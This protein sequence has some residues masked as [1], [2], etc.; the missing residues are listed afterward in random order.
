MIIKKRLIGIAVCTFFLFSLLIAQYFK[1]QIIDGE[2]WT[3]EALAQH[4]FI[5]KEPGKRG[6]FFANTSLKKGH[7]EKPLAFVADVTHFHLFID[8]VSIPEEVREDVSRSLSA[9]AQIA[10]EDIRP[11]FDRKSR[12][13]KL[14][15]WISRETKEAIQ[16]WWLPFAKSHKIARNA[17]YFVT[18]YKRSYPFGKLLGQV[19]HTIREMK[20]ETTHEGLPTGGLESYFNDLVKGKMGKKKLMRSPL[21]SL[22]IDKVIQSPDHG[23]DIYLTINHTIQAICEEEIE[24]GVRSANA[25]G[26]W[27]V[28]LDPYTGDVLALAQYPFFDPSCYSEYFNDPTKIENTKI[29]PLTD[30]FELGSIMKPITIATAL[31]A[32]EELASQGKAALFDPNEVINTTRSQFPGRGGKPLKDVHL[33]HKLNMYMAIQKSSNVYMAQIIE[34]VVGTLGNDWYRSVLT[35][36]FGF[37]EKTGLEL[38]G[39]ATGIVPTPGKLHPNGTLEWSTPTPYSLCMGYNMLATSMQMLR[40]FAVFANGG[41]LIKPTIVRKI[42]KTNAEGQEEVIVDNTTVERRKAFKQVLSTKTVQEVVKAM[43]YT[44]KPDG[45]ARLGEVSGYSEAGK[46]GTAEKIVGGSYSKSL[47]M[48]SFIGFAPANLDP[49]VRSRFVLIVTIDEPEVRILPGGIKQH[50][51]GRAAAPIFSEISRRTLEYLGVNP[52]DPCG[53]PKGDPRHDEA[54]ADWVKEVQSLK[55]LYEQWNRKK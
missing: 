52:D 35:D 13:R 26:G 1:I 7:P 47:H 19:L 54:K 11:E 21:N 33:H 49:K 10:Y 42:V 4:E 9:I 12:S 17:V 41:F 28:M 43:K 18:D 50:H 53:Y 8:P 29:K 46:T 31:K 24:K 25:K 16:K 37:G 36:T 32:N 27:A 55:V 3:K 39:E 30:A 2:K 15:M 40:A 48:T 14:S 44:T 6:T 5:V 38:P 51:G 45:T 23:A 20:D 34:R 22:D